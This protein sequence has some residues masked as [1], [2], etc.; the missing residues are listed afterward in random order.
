[1]I[2]GVPILKH[3]RVLNINTIHLFHFFFRNSAVSTG[4]SSDGEAGSQ[5]GDV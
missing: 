2:V 5:L 1:M 4:L 3:F